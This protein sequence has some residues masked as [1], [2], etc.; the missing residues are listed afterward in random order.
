[1]H[2]RFVSLNK[3]RTPSTSNR[4]RNRSVGSGAKGSTDGSSG[5]KKMKTAL[6][7]RQN[8]QPDIDNVLKDIKPALEEHIRETKAN[9]EEMCNKLDKLVDQLHNLPANLAAAL[10]M[11]MNKP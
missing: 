3:I 10:A 11:L 5:V 9:Q 1:M 4:K 8:M 2:G 7:A 6:G